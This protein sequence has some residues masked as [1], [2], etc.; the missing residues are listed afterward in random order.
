MNGP[1]GICLD[2]TLPTGYVAVPWEDG[3][4]RFPLLT[5]LRRHHNFARCSQ[6]P[7]DRPAVVIDH[8]WP[9]CDEGNKC[10]KHRN[11]K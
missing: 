5:A 8:L 10:E 6:R 3:W 2:Y 7:C 4:R 11:K 9:N 1:A